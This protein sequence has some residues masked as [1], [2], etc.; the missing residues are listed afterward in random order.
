MVTERRDTE[1]DRTGFDETKNYFSDAL[2]KV[3]PERF[4]RRAVGVAVATDKETYRRG[5][6][7]EITVEFDNRLPVP[8]EVPTP[9][10]RRWGWTV[11]GLLE[12]SEEKRY[13]RD[14]PLTF[15]FRAGETK[16]VTTTWNGRIRRTNGAGLDR[17]EL[18]ERGTYT[19][20]AFLA[21]DGERPTDSTR[22]RID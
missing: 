20:E 2:A 15:P 4:A 9:G 11:D 10:Q 13:V 12:A 5:E 16:T 1:A 3:V 8:V 17:S 7:V 22:I 21:V 19:I 14:R 18:P 6:P